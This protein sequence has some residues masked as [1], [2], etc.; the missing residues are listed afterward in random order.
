M[1]VVS[2]VI[3]TL[4]ALGDGQVIIV[5]TGSSYIKEIGPS[6]SRPDAF[7]VNA[8]HSFFVVVVRHNQ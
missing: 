2:I 6:F 8:V 5:A 3:E 7:A 1:P 4:P